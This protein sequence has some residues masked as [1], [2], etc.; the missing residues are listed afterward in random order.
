V[1]LC[2]SLADKRLLYAA[3]GPTLSSWD[4]ASKWGVVHSFK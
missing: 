2:R 1:L 4:L 3:S